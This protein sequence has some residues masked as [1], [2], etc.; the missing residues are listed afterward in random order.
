MDIIRADFLI[1]QA[2]QRGEDEPRKTSLIFPRLREQSHVR[3]RLAEHRGGGLV[4][5]IGFWTRDD[6][7]QRPRTLVDFALVIG[8][9][10]GDLIA[11]GE[12]LDL[13]LAEARTVRIRECA[14]WNAQRMTGAAN[15]LVH[16]EAALKLRLVVNAE[17][18][19]ETPVLARRLRLF[20]LLLRQRR[21][22]ARERER[23]GGGG[24]G[25]EFDTDHR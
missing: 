15:L 1:L 22:R 2:R 6:V 4:V 17:H 7:G 16:L 3:R 13:I 12:R 23:H 18:A 14:E 21:Q 8:L 19:G 10:V 24:K 5:R 25:G 9:R 11:G 20:S